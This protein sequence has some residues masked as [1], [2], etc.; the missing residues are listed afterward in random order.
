[1][2]PERNS[3]ICREHTIVD[4]L[5]MVEITQREQ[6]KSQGWEKRTGKEVH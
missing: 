3:L 5:D 6:R 2:L 4:A 1:M